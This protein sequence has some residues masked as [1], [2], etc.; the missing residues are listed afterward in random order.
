MSRDIQKM[1]EYDR[2]RAQNL[3]RKANKKAY[4]Q[5]DK[6]K[7]T[8]KAYNQSDKGKATRKAYEQ[9]DAAKAVRKAYEQSCITYPRPQS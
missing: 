4:K 1:R 2:K 5:S 9:S 7:A 3:V 6:C 8:R